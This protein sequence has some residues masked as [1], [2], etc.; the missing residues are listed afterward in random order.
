MTAAPG[1]K[2]AVPVTH[3]DHVVVA[4]MVCR[5][6]DRFNVHEADEVSRHQRAQ[7]ERGYRADGWGNGGGEWYCPVCRA[8]NTPKETA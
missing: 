1:V 5:G 2:V 7:L 8:S 6:C 3:G 4:L